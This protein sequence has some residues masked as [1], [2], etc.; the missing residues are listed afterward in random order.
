MKHSQ[1]LSFADVIKLFRKIANPGDCVKLQ[2]DVNHV[3]D[4]CK[5]NCMSLNREKCIVVSNELSDEICS[6]III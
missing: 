3:N 1:I 5:L 2:Y 6:I 4:W